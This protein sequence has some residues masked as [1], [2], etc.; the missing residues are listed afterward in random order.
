M[1]DQPP[2]QRNSRLVIVIGVLFWMKQTGS[3][4]SHSS[5]PIFLKIDLYEIVCAYAVNMLSLLLAKQYPLCEN[6]TFW[7]VRL[8]CAGTPA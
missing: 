1:R 6:V 5:N 7:G 4:S 2:L 8:P 3:L